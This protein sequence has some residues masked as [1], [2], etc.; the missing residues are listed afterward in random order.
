LPILKAGQVD[1]NDPL[2]QASELSPL[3]LKRIKASK[4]GGSWRDWD[5]RLIAAC[6]KKKTGKTYPS[7]YGRMKWHETRVRFW[8]EK[9]EANVRRDKRNAR[10]LRKQ[11]WSV[12]TVWECETREIERLSNRLERAFKKKKPIPSREVGYN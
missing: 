12:L 9:F 7:V 11:G 2:H 10:L 5:S 3:N 6:H 1:A 4:Q 8:Q